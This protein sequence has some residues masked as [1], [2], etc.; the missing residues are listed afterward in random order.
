MNRREFSF[1]T[2]RANELFLK[3]SLWT[4]IKNPHVP[5]GRIGRLGKPHFPQTKRF[6]ISVSFSLSLYVRAIDLLGPAWTATEFRGSRHNTYF[7]PTNYAFEKLDDAELRQTLNSPA[8]ARR[9]LDNHRADR[10]LPSTLIKQRGWQYEFR[11]ENEITVRMA[12]GG[13]GLTVKVREKPLFF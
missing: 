9:M 5:N 8:Y 1:R 4:Y 13:N 3:L 11:T 6:F 10:V 7:I 2:S 12:Y